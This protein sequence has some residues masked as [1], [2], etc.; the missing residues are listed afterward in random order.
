MPLQ[1]ELAE[2]YVLVIFICF[3]P[4][5]TSCIM[6]NLYPP[7]SF[8]DTDTVWMCNQNAAI[9]AQFGRKDLAHIWSLGALLATPTLVNNNRTQDPETPWAQNPFGRKLLH[10]M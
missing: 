7:T 3:L 2:R 1:L 9:A 6:F 8:S 10:A 5:Y 4:R